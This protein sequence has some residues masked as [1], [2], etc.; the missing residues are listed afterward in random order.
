MLTVTLKKLA[1]QV[2]LVGGSYL[3]A[4]CSTAEIVNADVQKITVEPWTEAVLSVTDLDV[5]ARFFKEIGGYIEKHR[6]VMDPSEIK[7]WGLPSK[8]S[9][10]VM[11]LGPRGRQQGSVR[12]V[13]FSNAGN[14]QPMRPGSRAWDT[15]CYFS[16]MIRMKDMQSIYDDAVA[17]GW[18]T[19][20]PITR[21]TFGESSLNVVIFR[22]PDGIQ[23]QGYERLKPPLP[24]TIPDF[25]RLTR[26]FNMMQIVTDRDATYNFF[27]AVLGFDTFYKGKPYTAKIPT[28]TPLGIPINLTTTAAYQ[29]GIVY[30]I[31]GEFGRMEMIEMMGLDGADYSARCTAPNL[32]ILAVRFR[33]DSAKVAADKIQARGW[34]ISEPLMKVTIKGLGDV[35]LFSV[36]APDGAIIQFYSP[37]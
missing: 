11:V 6:D 32:G 10:E 37:A 4:G 15:G 9:A 8:A 27:T 36:K 28:P 3:F 35:M 5:T 16:M 2:I 20:T 22:G 33:V 18:W 1:A 31:E 30:P 24:P 13:T 29:A 21:L 14:R 17:M 19:E 26:P 25:D 23:L 12:L 7:A 34:K